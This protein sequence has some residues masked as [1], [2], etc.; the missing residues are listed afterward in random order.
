LESTTSMHE[1]K[2]DHLNN[3]VRETV[4]RKDETIA[5]L[6]EQLDS[7]TLRMKEFERLLGSG[8]SVLTGL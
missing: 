8:S 4:F 1:Q 6:Q 7:A 2:L 5:A 3:R